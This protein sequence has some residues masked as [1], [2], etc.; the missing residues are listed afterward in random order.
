LPEIDERLGSGFDGW[1][2][3]GSSS[4]HDSEDGSSD[5]V[6]ELHFGGWLNSGRDLRIKVEKL[7]RDV[8]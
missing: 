5:D 4:C 8:D 3:Y 7:L 6:C 2:G 1:V